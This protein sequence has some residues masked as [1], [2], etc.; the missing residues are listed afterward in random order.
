MHYGIGRA[1]PSLGIPTPSLVTSGGDTHPEEEY[2]V[3][4][5]ETE[6]QTVSKRTICIL[7]ECCLVT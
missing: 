3:V 7:L 4:A 2:L 1:S 6:T 5:T